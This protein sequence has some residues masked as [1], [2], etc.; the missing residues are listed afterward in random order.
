MTIR[1]PGAFACLAMGLVLGWAIPA[2]RPTVLRADAPASPS[3][4]AWDLSR[5]QITSGPVAILPSAGLKAAVPLEAV[6]YLDYR[7]GRLLAG[8]PTGQPTAQE[9]ANGPVNADRL[10]TEFAERDL[11]RDFPLPPGVE[12]HFLM[13]V[14]RQG[15]ANPEGWAPL[16]VIEAATGQMASYRVKPE[17]VG[18]TAQTKI[19]LLEKKSL[20][21]TGLPPVTR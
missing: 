13:T 14:C 20:G 11:A 2:L 19:L 4:S 6:Y 21:R 18:N 5:C 9:S 3:P 7:G 12:P 8:L 15:S 1:R 17:M 10:V 16:Y